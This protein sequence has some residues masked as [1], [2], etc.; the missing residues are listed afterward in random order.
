MPRDLAI[1]HD[2]HHH[3][4]IRYVVSVLALLGATGCL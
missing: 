1:D 4:P 3:S 2:A